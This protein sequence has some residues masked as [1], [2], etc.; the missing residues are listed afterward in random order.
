MILRDWGNTYKKNMERIAPV[1]DEIEEKYKN[2]KKGIFL[3]NDT[4]ANVFL[5]LLVRKYGTLP[6]D[7]QI[8]GF[9][10][11]PISSEAIIPISTVGQQIDKIAYQAMELLVMQMNEKKK[12]RPVPLEG[13]IHKVVT[14]ILIRRETT[15]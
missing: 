13:P 11:S 9:D 12:R 15:S 8:V 10:G 14:P 7:Y 3:S 4:L 2:R 6:G 5:N 1:L